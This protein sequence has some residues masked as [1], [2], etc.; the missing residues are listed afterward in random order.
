MVNVLELLHEVNMG[1]VLELLHEVNMGNVLD[2][3]KLKCLDRCTNVGTVQS[4]LT[5]IH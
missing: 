5:S 3:V 4:F 2:N 1:N